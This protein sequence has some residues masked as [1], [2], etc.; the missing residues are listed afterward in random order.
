MKINRIVSIVSLVLVVLLGA[1]SAVS[2]PLSGSDRDAVLAYSEAK[3][4][5]LMQSMNNNDLAAFSR[6]LDDKMKGAF[7]ADSFAKMQSQIGGKIGKYVSRQVS[8][9][10][11]TGDYVTIIYAA[12]FENEDAVT[13]RVSLETAEPHRVSGLWFDSAKLRQQ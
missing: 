1:C 13:M 12:R 7:T 5:N 6:D 4:D 8:T 2:L 10:L 9:V 11:R 3:V